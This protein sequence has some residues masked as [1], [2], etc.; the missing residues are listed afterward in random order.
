MKKSEPEAKQE[1]ITDKSTEQKENGMRSF[2]YLC[3]RNMIFCCKECDKIILTNA[4]IEKILRL[5][6][7][8]ICF[9]LK[10]EADKSELMEKFKS[11]IVI[12]SQ[13]KVINNKEFNNVGINEV[14]CNRCNNLIGV[15]M[16]QTDDIQ[17]FML[18]TFVIKHDSMKYYMSEELG[19]KPYNFSFRTETIKNMDKKA[20]ETE[21]YIL[22]GGQRIQQFFEMLSSQK[23]DINNF[24]TKIKDLDKLGD[25]L[26]YLIDKKYI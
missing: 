20:T 1:I 25:I 6:T 4:L 5:K 24:E 23:N 21:E 22:K 15:R 8:K 11:S 2:G 13:L 19:I 14:N 17:I 12:Q 10:D 7:G 9:I 18:N 3:K 26:T 16:K